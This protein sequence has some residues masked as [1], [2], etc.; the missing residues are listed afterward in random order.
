MKSSVS[1]PEGFE[2]PSENPTISFSSEEG[3]FYGLKHGH[4]RAWM[5]IMQVVKIHEDSTSGSAQFLG[6][7]LVK[8]YQRKQEHGISTTEEL[9]GQPSKKPLARQKE[10]SKHKL[11]H[12]E[13]SG[14][15]S[16]QEKGEEGDV[17]DA[18][19]GTSYF[20]LA[21]IQPFS[22]TKNELKSETIDA[23]R[24]GLTKIK[25]EVDSSTVIGEKSKVREESDS[26]IPDPSHQTVTSTPPVIA[27]F[28]DITPFIAL[29]SSVEDWSKNVERTKLDNALLKVLERH[30]ADLIEKYS[31]LPGPESVKNQESEK[32][33]KEIIRAKKEQVASST[34]TIEK[35][36]IKS[37]NRNTANYHLYHALMEALIADED[38][39]DK[40]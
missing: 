10:P 13:R 26:T 4:Q 39:M 16:D 27:P 7:R 29:S 15:G 1:Q 12:S 30:T 14:F 24:N 18:V 35:G 22:A 3:F 34:M 19:H 17:D 20:A 2:G 38:A 40:E 28:T 23:A 36:G 25:E 9:L 5:R 8:W 31:V 33:P 37:A 21:W 11:S 6:D 32:S